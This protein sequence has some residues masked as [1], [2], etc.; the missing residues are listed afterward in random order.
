M[1]AEIGV[2]ISIH[3]VRSS[4]QTFFYSFVCSKTKDFVSLAFLQQMT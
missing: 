3:K 1:E 2:Q 4:T